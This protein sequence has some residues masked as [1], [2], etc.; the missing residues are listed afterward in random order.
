[1]SMSIHGREE[2]SC[3]MAPRPHGRATASTQNHR[4]LAPKYLSLVAVVAP[5]SSNPTFLPPSSPASRQSPAL[6]LPPSRR[7]QPKTISPN[8]KLHDYILQLFSHKSVANQR[9]FRP[10]SLFASMQAT[11][12][13]FHASHQCSLPAFQTQR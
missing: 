8:T 11:S 2:I 10:S 1:M 3:G 13:S 7:M 12:L 5:A 6:P 9:R 4:R